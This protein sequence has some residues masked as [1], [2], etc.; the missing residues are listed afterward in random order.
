[1]YEYN[2]ADCVCVWQEGKNQQSRNMKNRALKIKMLQQKKKKNTI[3]D[4]FPK[5][6][7][8]NEK[9][10]SDELVNKQVTPYCQLRL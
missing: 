1:M 10:W 5:V 2:L 4:S 7:F 6:I 9:I 8:Q 3:S